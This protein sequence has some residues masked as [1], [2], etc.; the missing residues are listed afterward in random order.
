MSRKQKIIVSVVGI[1]IVLLALL[2]ITYAYYLTRIQG[3]TNT[4]S[5]SV[6]TAD[7]KLIYGDGNGLVTAENIMP[8]TTIEKTFTVTNNG[9]AKIDNY[10]V[11]LE[12]VIN[13]L[14]RTEDLTYELVC[15]STSGSCTGTSGEFPTLAGI[16]I[17]NS[18]DVG[19]T[20]TYKLTVTY[21][22]LD[23]IDQSDDMGSSI[24]AFVQIYDMKDVVDI[25]GTITGA[26]EDDYAQINSVKKVSQIVNG[27]YKFAGVLPGSHTIKICR[28]TDIN[29]D[30]P[31][32]IKTI[33]VN[34]GT[35]PS[36]VE[37]TIT[38]SEASQS[39]NLDINLSTGE[40]SITPIVKDYTIF[41]DGTLANAIESNHK[42]TKNNTTPTFDDMATLEEGLYETEDDYGR[43]LYFRG[44][45]TNNYVKFAGFTWRVVRINGD[46]SVRLILDGV[47]NTVKK[48]GESTSPGTYSK[49]NSVGD[50]N[51][52]IGYMYGLAGV[53][54]SIEGCLTY[55]DTTTS[56]INITSTYSDKN[57]CESNGGKWVNGAYEATH[58]NITSSLIKQKLDAFYEGYLT[59]SYYNNEN[60]LITNENNKD[61]YG[62]GYEEYISDTLFCA[63]KTRASNNLSKG[64]GTIATYYR[65][66]N[67]VGITGTLKPSLK[68][69]AVDEIVDTAL[70]DEQLAISRYTV[71]QT[72]ITNGKTT[73]KVNKDLKYPIALLT[74]DE[75][76]MAGA[77]KDKINDYY[78]L[79]YTTGSFFWWTMTPIQIN[80][81]PL[82]FM[83]ISYYN[84]SLGGNGV[85]SNDWTNGQHS[86]RPVINLR[87]DILVDTGD[88]TEE[89][90]YTIKLPS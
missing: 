67:R 80:T 71:N 53:T 6:T 37:D 22:N 59:S 3:N 77:Y 81:N 76:V 33:V 27:K 17:T 1:T 4:N 24:S 83:Y 39:V 86:I 48:E 66:T 14:S 34:A 85:T 51:A 2:G 36:V 43:T 78:Y 44:A 60:E 9:N 69:A 72:S 15:K 26:E 45:Q 8:G 29:C 47:L 74:V 46:G 28:V 7:L 75:L 10:A 32:L 49:F 64:Y 11:Y 82:A 13:T 40:T 18:I 41:S 65:A 31:K 50:D 56:T 63:D 5:I 84:K 79:E 57:S 20:H 61:Q 58:A 90:P 87:N 35:T 23:T 16:I 54:E 62:N 52:Y 55:D 12:E 19:V 38:I 21:A 88:G 73:I 89:S 42:I 68:C 30:S 25:A 70:T